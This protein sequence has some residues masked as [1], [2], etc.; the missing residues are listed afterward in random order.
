[1][2]DIER[3]IEVPEEQKQPDYAGFEMTQERRDR[4]MHRK[5]VGGQWDELA[6]L[7]LEFLVG[8]GLKRKH[9]FL[10]VGCGAL[11]AGR[12]LVDYL[13][14]GH[15]YGLDVNNDL[16][17]AGYELELTEEQRARLPVSNLHSTD[18]F[19]ADFGVRFDMAIAQSVFT[20]IDLNLMRL[21]LHRVAQ[22]MRPGG[23][24]FVTFFE[25]EDDVQLDLIQPNRLQFTERNRYWY[26]RRDL[27]WVAERAPWSVRYVGGW[28]HPRGQRM[29][30]YTRLRG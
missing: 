15:Y 28:K 7:Q 25:R 9:H 18:R 11:R 3:R 4:R 17:A 20:H 13:D 21:C 26:Y 10:D 14:P 16:I 29:V 12:H 2:I 1:M 24:F 22:A 5:F 19:D 30:E 27:E 23:R 8:Q 6:D